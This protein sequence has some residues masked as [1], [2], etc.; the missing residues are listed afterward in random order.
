MSQNV[1]IL[2]VKDYLL[3]IVT[4]VKFLNIFNYYFQNVKQKT[5]LSKLNAFHLFSHI[6]RIILVILFFV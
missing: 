2:M 5:I 1:D 6:F 4:P 3:S